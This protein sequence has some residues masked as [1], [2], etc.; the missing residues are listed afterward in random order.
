MRTENDKMDTSILSE[1]GLAQ[2]EID[3]YLTLISLKSATISEIISKAK[4]S[5]QSVYEIV[6]KLL[7]KGLISFVARDGKKQYIVTNPERLRDIQK[8]KLELLDKLLPEL[9]SKYRENKE[10]TNVEVFAGKEGMKAMTD[11]IWKV[12]KPTYVISNDAKIFE[13][14]KYYMP[15]FMQKRAKLG[16]KMRA[17]YSEKARVKKI[18]GE[19]FEIR[20]VP[21]QHSIPI[22]I[23]IYGDNSNIIVYSENPVAMHI[24]NKEVAQSF[25]QYFNL[26]WSLGKK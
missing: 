14:L 11:N 20:Y 12:G 21:E 3:V 26:M 22:S 15:Q 23:A 9:L 19:L 10:E 1:M 17:V 2:K 18:D 5:R 24:E 4:V 7:D 8:E 25:M 13:V 6:Q 16:I